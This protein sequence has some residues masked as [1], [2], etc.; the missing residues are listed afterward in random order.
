MSIDFQNNTCPDKNAE[1]CMRH[2][3]MLMLISFSMSSFATQSV[4]ESLKKQAAIEAEA[5]IEFITNNDIGPE[6]KKTL[7]NHIH[8]IAESFNKIGLIDH[9]L[10]G[11][12]VSNE[13]FTAF[14]LITLAAEKTKFPRE[15]IHAVISASCKDKEVVAF[16]EKLTQ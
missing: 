15:K 14:S 7:Q 11:K 16:K 5:Y 3:I 12:E 4:D 13:C 10:L 8:K 6:Q 2:I 1:V 9:N